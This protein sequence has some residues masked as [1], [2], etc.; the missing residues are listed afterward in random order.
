M[1]GK[2]TVLIM[3]AGTGGHVFPALSI[4]R[5]L[6][7]KAASIE[8]LGTPSGMENDLLNGSQIPLH[9]IAVSGLR[10]SGLKRKILAPIML[11]SAFAQS[12]NLLRKIQPDCVLGMGGF[13]C[14]PAGVAAKLLGKPLVLHE[15][16]AV[17]GLTNRLLA[18]I[19]DRV[20]EA[21]PN[22]F[23]SGSKVRCTGN[24]LRREIALLKSMPRV[25]KAD[26]EAVN[27]LVLGG[28][29]GAAAI[30]D[31]MPGVLRRLGSQAVS[32][33]HQT[34]K[35]KLEQTI[36]SY[37]Q[38]GFSLAE[39]LQVSSFIEDMP[40][41]YQWSDLVICRSGASTV[42][43]I[44]AA[45]KPSILIPYPYHR[46][47]QQVFNA[48]WL[49]TAGA[50][51]ILEQK[52]LTVDCLGKQIE[53]LIKPAGRLNEMGEKALSVAILDADAVIASE[54]LELANA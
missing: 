42:S 48:K 15:Q 28:S 54:C 10:G 29:Q 18:V 32:V 11:L 27:I 43:E 21:F 23:K 22:T 51:V 53:E 37:K 14:G 52:Q 30:N 39:G 35:H 40:K 49:E 36:E 44:A 26:G 50:A 16:N 13:V 12:I 6:Q 9:H 17:A 34:G 25:E 47:N 7:A 19:A 46:D 4:A 2:P 24:P 38:S 33:M 20:L 45:G 8:W 1:N 31:V 41:A 3:A 5:A